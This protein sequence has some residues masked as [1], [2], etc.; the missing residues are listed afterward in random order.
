MRKG[1]KSLKSTLAVQ[2]YGAQ[3]KTL[4]HV[5]KGDG[6]CVEVSHRIASCYE[7]QRGSHWLNQIQNSRHFLFY[8]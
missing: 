1:A 5:F 8:F 7:K 3:Y 2:N 6:V 4:L